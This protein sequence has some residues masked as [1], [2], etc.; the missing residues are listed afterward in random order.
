VFS[1]DPPTDAVARVPKNAVAGA[2]LHVAERGQGAAGPL[3]VLVHGSLDR[4][5]A[6]ARVVASEPLAGLHTLRYDRRGYGRSVD[7]GPPAGLD[8]HV[9]D[10]LE[11]VD[12]RPAVVVGHSYGGLVALVASIRG[13]EVVRAVAAFE[14]PQPWA[15]WWPEQSAGSA[16]AAAGPAD[17]AEAFLRRMVGDAR[18]EALPE[19][20]REARRRE[21][22]ALAAELTSVRAARPPL[23]P[24]DVRAPLVVG[25]G[26]RSPEHLRRSAAELA[27]AVAGAVLVEVEGADHGAH[28]THP[29]EFAAWARR[30]VDLVREER[31]AP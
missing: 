12:G 8:D 10:L 28:L 22:T 7:V 4:G 31:S 6:F 24:V 9:D 15:P 23:D 1:G 21:G 20:T 30:A 26:S 13:P 16:A 5:A 27:A 11:V 18:W 19:R 2:G 29:A 25:R 3:V 14:P 17:A